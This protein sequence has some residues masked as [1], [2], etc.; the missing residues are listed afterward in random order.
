METARYVWR[1]LTTQQRVEILS[2]RKKNERPWHSPPH[3]PNFGH[4]HFL[5][6]AACYNHAPHIGLSPKRLDDF[7]AALLN[8]L[9]EHNAKAVAWCVLPNHYHVLVEAPNIL[10]LLHALGRLHGRS[11][12][13]WNREENQRG[14]QVFHRSTERY[15]RSERH[16]LATINYVH[17]NPVHHGY[18]RLWTEWPW[19]S[20]G[21]FL[22]QLGRAEAERVWKEYPILDYGKTWDEA[23]I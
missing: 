22:E 12:F 4:L 14:R 5:V 20:A 18:V 6:S 9:P 3:L 7:S 15:M 23:E 10:K 8:L 2:W 17:N 1:Q 13:A 21:E 16:F 11:S 19:S